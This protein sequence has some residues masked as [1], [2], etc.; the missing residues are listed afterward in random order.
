[1]AIFELTRLCTDNGCM[2]DIDVEKLRRRG[3]ALECEVQVGAEKV[4]RKLA[5]VQL[6]ESIFFADVYTGSLYDEAGMCITSSNLRLLEVIE[7]A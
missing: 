1:M 6:G 5:P 7:G 4:I 2:V 3:K